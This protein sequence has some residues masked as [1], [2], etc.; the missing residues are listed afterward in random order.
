MG[1]IDSI[2]DWATKKST[3]DY[4]DGL[5]EYADKTSKDQ[6]PL[7]KKINESKKSPVFTGRHPDMIKGKF[8]ESLFEG[9]QKSIRE[10]IE[11][12]VR[13][14]YRVG[15]GIIST[16]NGKKVD[17]TDF[18]T[19]ERIKLSD[20]EDNIDERENYIKEKSMYYN[21]GNG[22]SSSQ[23][24]LFEPLSNKQTLSIEGEIYLALEK[25]HDLN[26]EVHKLSERLDDIDKKNSTPV[27]TSV[28]QASTQTL[29][30]ALDTVQEMEDS[31]KK[32]D[33]DVTKIDS[34]YGI[35][36]IKLAL[37]CSDV[38]NVEKILSI[39][40]NYEYIEE[41]KMF[42][43]KV[44]QTVLSSWTWDNIEAI[45][46]YCNNNDEVKIY[47]MA[48]D[49]DNPRGTKVPEELAMNYRQEFLKA[50][51]VIVIDSSTKKINIMKSRY[52]DTSI[53]N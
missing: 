7:P 41:D 17:H 11:S 3:K 15:N 53:T 27:S 40:Q 45:R 36:M 10:R 43:N 32:S 38:K 44:R 46:T 8:K 49:R 23:V 29:Q 37:R 20:I 30:N 14:D 35:G 50:N 2:V 39:L 12:I 19:Q 5:K 13:L 24:F 42:L 6:Q 31:A 1:L 26:E 48:S 25:L 4:Q 52:F 22:Y 34:R 51:L 47:D 33:S 28:T 21:H 9:I 16:V 18:I